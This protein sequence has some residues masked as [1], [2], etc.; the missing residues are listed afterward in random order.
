MEKHILFIK[1]RIKK[2]AGAWRVVL[3]KV[4]VVNFNQGLGRS[5]FRVVAI[6]LT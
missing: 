3:V 6:Y 1:R 2:R 4:N 5:Q